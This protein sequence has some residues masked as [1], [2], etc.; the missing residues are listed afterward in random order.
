[1][2]ILTFV[3]TS[4]KS[5]ATRSHLD[6]KAFPIGVSPIRSLYHSRGRTAAF[7]NV[8]N[9]IVNAL[10]APIRWLLHAA[11]LHRTLSFGYIRQRWLRTGLVVASIAL[12]VAT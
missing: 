5:A 8:R 1:M 2:A 9:R 3:F 10:L 4:H 11:T 7:R 12:G 6:L